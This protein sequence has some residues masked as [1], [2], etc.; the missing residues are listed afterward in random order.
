MRTRRSGQSLAEVMIV[1]ALIAIAAIFIVTVYGDEV[2][3]LFGTSD[4]SLAG[5]TDLE[6][7]DQRAPGGEK[8]N[9]DNFATQEN[10]ECSK[11]VCSF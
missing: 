9:M 11:G 2:R 5:E 4:G 3:K 6:H 1:L 7:G 10:P 8:H